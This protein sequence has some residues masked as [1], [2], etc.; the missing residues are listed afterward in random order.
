MF[1]LDQDTFETNID[2]F[3]ITFENLTSN[4]SLIEFS[5]FEEYELFDQIKDYY[6]R[7]NDQRL[8][9]QNELSKAPPHLSLKVMK[10][11]MVELL[12]SATL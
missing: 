1:D 5:Y 11:T 10:T 3:K 12:L 9:I 8:A 6:K 2:N 4:Y 7:I